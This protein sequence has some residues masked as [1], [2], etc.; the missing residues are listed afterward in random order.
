[1]KIKGKVIRW[2]K[3]KDCILDEKITQWWNFE[4][5]WKIGK[6]RWYIHPLC[7]LKFL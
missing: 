1:M 2:I 4:K 5:W 6:M 7:N 3:K